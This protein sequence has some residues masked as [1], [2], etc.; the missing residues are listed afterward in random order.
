MNLQQI[1]EGYL[2]RLVARDKELSSNAALLASATTSAT[3]SENRAMN[4]VT[5]RLYNSNPAKSCVA[6]IKKSLRKS[7]GLPIGEARSK[8]KRRV[9][10]GA[11]QRA[12]QQSGNSPPDCEDMSETQQGPSY[13]E[14]KK[15][16]K[17][18]SED[19]SELERQ[20]IAPGSDEDLEDAESEA[21]WSGI[22]S[23]ASDEGPS[24]AS[25]LV[26]DDESPIAGRGDVPLHN[27]DSAYLPSL[28][29]AGYVSGSDSEFSD[30]EDTTEGLTNKRNRRGQRARQKIWEKKFGKSAKHLQKPKKGSKGGRDEGWDMKRGAREEGAQSTR[31]I[32]RTQSKRDNARNDHG[33]STSNSLHSDG[34]S[35]R[36]PKS[37]QDA[38]L[39]PSWQAARETKARMRAADKVN[40]AGQKITFD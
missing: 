28:S 20:M 25:S 13:Y 32:N 40:F 29:M 39:H 33:F 31:E 6:D 21:S 7:I 9:D 35:S 36:A 4:N 27:T 26:G 19:F 34:F 37:T 12:A 23:Q 30:E 2:S 14:E 11:P 17:S 16:S 18:D 3:P 22:T 5:A 8:E 15:A 10:Q 1:A 24:V 38:P